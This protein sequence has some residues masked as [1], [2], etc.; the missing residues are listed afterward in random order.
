MNSQ[1]AWLAE[2]PVAYPRVRGDWTLRGPLGWA[3]L[4]P[5]SGVSRRYRPEKDRRLP[6]L[7]EAAQSGRIVGYRWGRRAVVER[8]SSFLKVVRASKRRSIVERHRA[9]ALALD[10][11]CE[12][13]AVIADDPRGWVELSRVGGRS[14]HDLLLEAHG[15]YPAPAIDRAIASAAEVLGRLHRSSPPTVLEPVKL[16]TPAEWRAMVER[17]EHPL[18]AATDAALSAVRVPEVRPL[19][20]VHADMHDKNVFVGGRGVG[21]LIDLDGVAL[22]APELDVGNLAAHLVL[23]ALQGGW[24]LEHGRRWALAL[25]EVYDR[26]SALDAA[27]L[28]SVMRHTWMRLACIYRFRASSRAFVPKLLDLA[29]DRVSISEA[30]AQA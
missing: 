24:K 8:E 15:S 21:G 27:L 16:T 6:G 13:P 23:R 29:V 4:V 9:M 26:Q 2:W 5:E 20:P 11:V 18:D 30:V 25:I 3:R 19:V 7:R 28:Q 12:T 17:A 14:L 22:G 1:P 10:G